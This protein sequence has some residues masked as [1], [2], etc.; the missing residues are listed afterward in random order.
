MVADSSGKEWKKLQV[1]EL[2]FGKEHGSSDC[3]ARP[4]SQADQARVGKDSQQ[5]RVKHDADH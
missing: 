1:C 2:G 3:S 4:G 5:V